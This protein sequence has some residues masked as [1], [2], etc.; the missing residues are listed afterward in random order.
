MELQIAAPHVTA[1]CVHPGGIKTNVARNALETGLADEAEREAEIAEF[2]TNFRTT[3][4]QAAETIL[5]AVVRDDPRVLIGADARVMDQLTRWAPRAYS[6][7]IRTR[8]DRRGLMA[9][10]LRRHPLRGARGRAAA[11]P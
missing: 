1:V 10:H 6:A 9:E 4:E 7:V 11:R 3:A 8:L 5:R 2:E